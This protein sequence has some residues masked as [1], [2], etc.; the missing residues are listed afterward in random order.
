MTYVSIAS[1]FQH[2]VS[3][4]VEVPLKE[5]EK[6]L[7]PLQ[8]LSRTGLNHTYLPTLSTCG[9]VSHHKAMQ[10]GEEWEP[11]NLSSV[12]PFKA[13]QALKNLL[14]QNLY[15]LVSWFMYSFFSVLYKRK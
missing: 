10:L 14:N 7:V 11:W 8:M 1:F 2:P 9:N 6:V 4:P 15:G 13:N 5:A 12:A 3:S